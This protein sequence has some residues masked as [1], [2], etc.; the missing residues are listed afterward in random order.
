MM[1]TRERLIG[2]DEY[3]ALRH[4]A[5][6]YI[7]FKPGTIRI[8]KAKFWRRVRKITRREIREEIECPQTR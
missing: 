3:D 1:G 4:R 5:R 8:I 6:R 7:S 2:G